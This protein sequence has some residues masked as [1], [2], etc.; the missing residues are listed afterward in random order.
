MSLDKKAILKEI[1]VLIRSIKVH[2][3][4]I[5]NEYRIPTIE[6]E[7]ITSKI[8]K[9]HEKSIIYNHLHYLEEEQ[10]Q[11]S[12]RMRFDHL[13]MK[14]AAEDELS[15]GMKVEPKPNEIYTTQ[16]KFEEKVASF[17]KPVEPEATKNIVDKVVETEVKLASIPE[18]IPAIEANEKAEEI[19][20]LKNEMP[21]QVSSFSPIKLSAK[22]GINDRF[23][24]IK[25]LFSGN[26]L[27]MEEAI[28]ALEQCQSAQALTDCLN[29]L[30]KSN[31][32]NE[33]DETVIDFMGLVK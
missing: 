25:N 28:K 7:L 3:D 15:D 17:E 20:P 1:E 13:I 2:Y 29:Q 14:H 22:I 24:F 31:N 33:E 32:W 21:A 6:L 10:L 19:L 8:R 23:R 27:V 11:S 18:A 9:L 12:K 16:L 5:E 26:G 30:K 4:N